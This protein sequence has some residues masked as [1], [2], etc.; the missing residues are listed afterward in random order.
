[1]EEELDRNPSI[2]AADI[3]VSVQDG[4][5]TLTGSVSSFSE[6]LRATAV[7][8]RVPGVDAVANAIVLRLPG[9]D[10]RSDAEIARL[11]FNALKGQAKV[12]DGRIKVAVT[13]GWVYLSGEV[14]SASQKSAAF[15]AANSLLG[16]KGV[17]NQVSVTPP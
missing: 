1:V 16:V 8:Q 11:A 15:D 6:K 5:V 2:N 12:P 14:D 17:F 9:T 7:A 10:A 3:G 4:I 13:N